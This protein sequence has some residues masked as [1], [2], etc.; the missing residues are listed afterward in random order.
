MIKLS[1]PMRL[2]VSL[3]PFAVL[4]SAAPSCCAA[5]QSPDEVVSAVVSN[6]IKIEASDHSRW[7]YRDAYKSP[8][9]DT[10]KLVVQ[11]AQGNLSETI[12]DH[13][14]PPGTQEHQADL[15]HIQQLLVDPA[16]RER[17][18][19]AE[20]HDGQQADD[21]MRLLPNAFIWQITGRDHG[22]ITLAYRPDPKFSPPSMSARVLSAMSGTL[23]VDEH[24]MRL[25]KLTG[26]LMQPVNFGWGLLG[27][28]DAGG[29][30]EVSRT[31]IAPG[32]WQITQTHVHI[33]GHAL[34]FKTIGDQEDEITSDYRPVPDDV[35]LDKAADMIRDGQLARDLHAETHFN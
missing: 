24:S 15:A 32:E 30:F 10:V 21:L 9:K 26:R 3:L 11:T 19:R 13:G 22:Q 35:D 5:T 1:R 2:V 33:N 4:L 18:R 27:H 8:E 14:Q 25:V 31:E 28:I 34:F 23:V 16:L 17:Q 20:A 7:M 6:E 12:E 29:T